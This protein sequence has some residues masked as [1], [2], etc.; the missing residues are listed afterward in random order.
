MFI[1]VDK[2]RLT[3]SWP[4]A[5]AGFNLGAGNVG[6]LCIELLFCDELLLEIAA[7]DNFLS[8]FVMLFFWFMEPEINSTWSC[9]NCLFLSSC[10][11]ALLSLV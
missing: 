2:V 10:E 9:L 5:R 7:C 6:F 3:S 11:F 8:G 4:L 1:G